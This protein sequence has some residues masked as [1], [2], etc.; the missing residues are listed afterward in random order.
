VPL[1]NIY[2]VIK[3]E[4]YALQSISETSVH[5][6]IQAHTPFFIKRNI[7]VSASNNFDLEYAKQ[8]SNTISR[9]QKKAVCHCQLHNGPHTA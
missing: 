7:S 9:M 1:F 4:C 5:H 2:A 8:T 3:E 6:G